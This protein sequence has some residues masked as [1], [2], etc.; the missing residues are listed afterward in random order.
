MDPLDLFGKW[1]GNLAFVT[2]GAEASSAMVLAYFSRNMAVRA[3]V[4]DV[5]INSFHLFAVVHK[6]DI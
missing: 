3:K 2:H 4:V 6:P 1:H 5:E